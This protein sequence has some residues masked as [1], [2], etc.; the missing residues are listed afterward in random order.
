MKSQPLLKAALLLILVLGWP[1]V[2]SWS[3][4]IAQDKVKN[5]QKYENKVVLVA[6]NDYKKSPQW[7]TIVEQYDDN[8]LLAFFPFQELLLNTLAKDRWELIQI[9]PLN[10]K[11]VVF[12]LKRALP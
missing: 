3:G 2:G 11:T 9:H 1:G 5:K 12:Y 7:K 10:A 4:A 6:Y 8:E